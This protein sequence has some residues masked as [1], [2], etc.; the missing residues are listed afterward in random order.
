MLLANLFRISTALSESVVGTVAQ[1]AIGAFV[2][3][4]ALGPKA[5][6]IVFLAET[7]A[8]VL[9]SL[10]GAEL[11]PTIFRTKWKEALIVGLVGF[12]G[13]FIGSAL[14]AHFFLE[15]TWMAS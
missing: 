14:I 4:E 7:G 2:G 10:A 15:S 12:A 8:I 9:T 13:P 1:L 11:D 3:T 6:W 5:P